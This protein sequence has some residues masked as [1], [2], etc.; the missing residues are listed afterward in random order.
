MPW[1]L[2]TFGVISGAALLCYAV[3]LVLTLHNGLGRR[4]DRYFAAYLGSMAVWSLG[5]LMMYA[6]PADALAWNRVMLSGVVV[7]PL[8]FYGFV[9]G[10]RGRSGQGLAIKLGAAAMVVMLALNLLGYLV[11]DVSVTQNGL[12]GFDF[13]YGFD[14]D[15]PGWEPHFQIGRTF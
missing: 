9:Q 8:V 4:V 15:N 11:L 13:G 10:F 1:S 7:M 5:A 6:D 12:I 3:L 2:T 14:K